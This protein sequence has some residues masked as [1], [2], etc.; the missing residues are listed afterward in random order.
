MINI[1]KKTYLIN[2]LNLL[3]ICFLFEIIFTLTG[4]NRNDSD[5]T[6]ISI[7]SW[8]I[9]FLVY[10]ISKHYKTSL[11]RFMLFFFAYGL[12]Y[13]IIRS[14]L[15]IFDFIEPNYYTRHIYFFTELTEE[16]PPFATNDSAF[17]FWQTGA[18][19]GCFNPYNSS[20]LLITFFTISP[21]ALFECLLKA[22][23]PN[24]FILI[25]IQLPISYFTKQVF[26]WS[27]K[28]N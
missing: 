15:S 12:V 4:Y 11:D 14:N 24:L 5:F 17:L 28:I 22:I 25:L 19:A 1:S 20:N 23:F 13:M 27:S 2:I 7:W 16:R 8:F 18:A 9:V 10:R 21:I 3:I 26:N 6:G